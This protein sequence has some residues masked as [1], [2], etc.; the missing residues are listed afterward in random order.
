[1]RNLD[2]ITMAQTIG[3]VIPDKSDAAKLQKGELKPQGKGFKKPFGKMF[4][5]K[6]VQ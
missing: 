1:M 2:L 6:K 4:V 5:Q 3:R